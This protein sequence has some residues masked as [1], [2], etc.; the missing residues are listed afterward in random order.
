MR[1]FASAIDVGSGSRPVTVHSGNVRASDVSPAPAP[2]PTSKIVPPPDS[3]LISSGIAGSSTLGRNSS[4]AAL[5]NAWI[6]STM[7]AP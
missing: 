7:S 5:L 6:A 1:R 3:L 4:Y 2:Q